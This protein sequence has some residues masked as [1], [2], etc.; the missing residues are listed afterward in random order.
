MFTKIGKLNTHSEYRNSSVGVLKPSTF[1]K[2]NLWKLSAL[3]EIE[4][5][6]G[7]ICSLFIAKRLLPKTQKFFEFVVGLL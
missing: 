4:E 3:I 2:V 5:G 7:L 1:T 6:Y